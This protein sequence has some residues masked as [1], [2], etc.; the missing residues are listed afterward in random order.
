MSNQFDVIVFGATSFVGQLLCQYLVDT[1]NGDGQESLNWAMAGRSQTKLDELKLQLQQPALSV[2]VADAADESALRDLCQQTRVIVSTVGPYALYGEPLI[3][4]C[5]ESGTDYC[6]LTG[7]V[8]WIRLMLDRYEDTAQ[9]SG[10]RIVHCSGFDS[11]P[12][13]MGVYFTQKKAKEVLGS[14]CT[15]ISMRVKAAKGGLSGGTL[16]SMIN[17]TREA[18]KDPALRRQ[19]ANPY[20]ICSES[21]NLKTKQDD[22]QTPTYDSGFGAWLAPF[23]MAAINSRVVFRSNALAEYPYGKDF[24]YNEAM[25]MGSGFKGRLQST[26]F[27]A[28]LGLFMLSLV[29][30]PTRWF[31]ERFVLPKPGEGPSPKAQK[32]GFYDIRF[33]GKTAD[34]QEI[35][36]RV[37]GQGD[38]GYSSTARMLGQVAAGLALDF[39]DHQQK[40]GKSGG[41]W[42]TSTLFGDRLIERLEKDADIT[43]E[44]LRS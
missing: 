3:K 23:I 22:V 28:G 4:V 21:E 25:L 24:R 2:L 17:I 8:Q 18:A 34:G 37:V 7:E 27:V 38:P 26:L 31:M 36:T 32:A 12:S 44:V 11:I 42:T 1:F 16:A 29:I 20:L 43:F 6:D 39:H 35:R 40:Q 41:F 33:L 5:A 30:K 19:L 13:D 14:F 9:K 10:A 15:D